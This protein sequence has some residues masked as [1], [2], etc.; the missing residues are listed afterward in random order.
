[1][2]ENTDDRIEVFSTDDQK[3]K[4]VGEM[5][6][7]N[8]SRKILQQLFKEELSATEIAQKSDISLQLVKYHI[9]KMMDLDM[10]KIARVEKNS[11]KS[12]HELLQGYKVCNSN[13]PIPSIRACKRK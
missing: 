3:I 4:Q 8:S 11:K 7:N 1:M 5:L 13:S 9:N 6:T 2:D 12:G 10:V